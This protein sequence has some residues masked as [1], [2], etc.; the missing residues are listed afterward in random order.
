M[1]LLTKYASQNIQFQKQK[2][3]YF[4][5]IVDNEAYQPLI[6]SSRFREIESVRDGLIL[7]N[8]QSKK[9]L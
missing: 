6:T 7:T 1:K 5:R 8:G 3:K 9:H 2:S 4:G